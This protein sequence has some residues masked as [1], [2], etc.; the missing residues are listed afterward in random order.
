MSEAERWSCRDIS[1]K[2]L[3][4]MGRRMGGCN[5]DAGTQIVVAKQAP[6]T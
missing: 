2:R 5:Y 3:G 4:L 1:V 6:S